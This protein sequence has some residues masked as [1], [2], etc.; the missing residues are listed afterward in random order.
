[1]KYCVKI[2]S[3]CVLNFIDR[4]LTIEPVHI[5][6]QDVDMVSQ[7][8]I[9]GPGVNLKWTG[10]KGGRGWGTELTRSP[11]PFRVLVAAVERGKGW[12]ELGRVRIPLAGA[13]GLPSTT[14]QPPCLYWE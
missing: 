6:Q 7:I 2:R 4:V 1:M 9:W 10:P 12:L 8:G 5:H 13:P 3:Y 14:Q 11:S